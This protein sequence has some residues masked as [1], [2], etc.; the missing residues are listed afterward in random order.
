MSTYA[1]KRVLK[2]AEQRMTAKPDDG[3]TQATAKNWPVSLRTWWL[4]ITRKRRQVPT[5]GLWRRF[6]D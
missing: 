3:I 6:G 4:T 2:E 5:L 1:A